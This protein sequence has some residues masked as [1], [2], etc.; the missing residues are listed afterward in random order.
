M[1]SVN[2]DANRLIIA[3]IVSST[4][5]L[6]CMWRREVRIDSEGVVGTTDAIGV[7][8]VYYLDGWGSIGRT[9]RMCSPHARAQRFDLELQVGCGVYLKWVIWEHR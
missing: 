5:M 6:T 7:Y 1:P 8:F 3:K 4:Y 2:K 9:A